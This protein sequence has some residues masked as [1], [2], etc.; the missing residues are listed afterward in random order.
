MV[1]VV[2][3]CQWQSLSKFFS[4]YIAG[5]KRLKSLKSLGSVVCGMSLSF[6]IGTK[7]DG[8]QLMNSS[9][10]IPRS[11]MGVLFYLLKS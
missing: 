5:W 4:N 6:C 7:G 2:S 3:K 11:A 1:R 10:G 8:L 9:G